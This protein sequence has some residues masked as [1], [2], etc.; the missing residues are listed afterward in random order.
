VPHAANLY[1]LSKCTEGNGV[2]FIKEPPVLSEASIA[3]LTDPELALDGKI[4]IEF[5]FDIADDFDVRWEATIYPGGRLLVH[6]PTTALP[7]GSKESF[8]RL[9]EF[10]EEDLECR[11]VYIQFGKH[12]SDRAHL[13]RTFMYFGFAM[14]PPDITPL[15]T[16]IDNITMVYHIN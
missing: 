9:L 10:A 6:V 15:P 16:N 12:R 11:S 4:G 13:V 14:L 7:E 8:I 2:G 3:E 5:V 1:T